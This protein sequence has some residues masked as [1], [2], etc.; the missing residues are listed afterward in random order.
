MLSSIRKALRSVLD[1]GRSCNTRRRERGKSQAKENAHLDNLRL[2]TS[3]SCIIVAY[4]A[5]VRSIRL[6]YGVLAFTEAPRSSIVRPWSV[7]IARALLDVILALTVACD[8]S[9]NHLT[10]YILSTVSTAFWPSGESFQI[11]YRPPRLIAD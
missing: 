8:L 5:D 7:A 11:V 1:D 2:V 9:R 6:A 10:L 4:H 3:H